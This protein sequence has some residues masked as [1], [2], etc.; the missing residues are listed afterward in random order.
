MRQ[1][2]LQNANKMFHLH[3]SFDKIALRI[4]K[5]KMLEPDF[6]PTKVTNSRNDLWRI[7]YRIIAFCENRIQ[8]M[9]RD[10]AM[11]E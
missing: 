4:K 7:P 8:Q 3:N 1:I 5:K 11:V 9:E 6:D 10:P 2:G